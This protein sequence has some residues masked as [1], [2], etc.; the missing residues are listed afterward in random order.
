VFDLEAEVRAWRGALAAKGE[1]RDEELD[2]LESHLRDEAAELSASGLAADE[3]FLV[4]AKRLGNLDAVASEFARASGEELWKRIVLEPAGPE[5]RAKSRRALLAALG[6]ALL[7]ALAAKL[8]SLLGLDLGTKAGYAAFL[9]LGA[10]YFMPF[11]G[12]YLLLGRASDWKAFAAAAF[13]YAAPAALLAAY[14]AQEGS[15]TVLLSAIHMP[16]AIWLATA[17]AYCGSRWRD[18]GRRMDFLRYTG[19]AFLYGILLGCGVGVLDALVM[20]L[21]RSI[22]V[23]ARV[24]SRDWLMPAGLSAAGLGAGVLARAKRN[25]IENFAP[26]LA[27]IFAPLFLV[28]LAAFLAATAARGRDPFAQREL[29]IAFDFMLALVLG[30]VLFSLSAREPRRPAGFEDWAALLLVLTALAID[31]FALRAIALRIGSYGWSP[32]KIAALGENLLLFVDLGGLALGYLLFLGKRR[33]IE[34]AVRWQ[35]AFLLP[36][37]AWAAIVALA[38]PLIFRGV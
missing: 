26:V 17:V 9:R 5:S 35:T 3:A 18:P 23:D 29:L 33:G 37:F 14:P 36:V 7:A 32:N 31:L 2:E 28:A 4:S 12:F 10:F 20:E 13:G 19:E 25:V 30:L 38:F 11:V 15:Q 24:F 22:G 6:L 21:F 1:L 16:I 8:P 27:R 34:A